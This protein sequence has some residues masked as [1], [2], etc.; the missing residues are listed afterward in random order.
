MSSG[1][2][3]RDHP[4]LAK[5]PGHP[6][7]LYRGEDGILWRVPSGYLGSAHSRRLVEPTSAWVTCDRRVSRRS[8]FARGVLESRCGDSER[9]LEGWRVDVAQV[10]VEGDE[11]AGDAGP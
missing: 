8:R 7:A 5:Y 4:S 2:Q 11:E 6:T 3:P 10:G 9:V 1:E